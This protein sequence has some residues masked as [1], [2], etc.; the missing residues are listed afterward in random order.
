MESSIASGLKPMYRMPVSFGPCAGPRNVPADASY[1]AGALRTASISVSALSDAD[2]LTEL[3]PDGC[4]LDGEPVLTAMITRMYDIGWLAGRSY[5][6]LRVTLPVQFHHQGELLRGNFMPVLWESLADPIVT[7]RDELGHPKLWAEIPDP[8]MTTDGPTERRISGTASWLGFRFFELKATGLRDTPPPPRADGPGH[9]LTAKY[10]PRTGSWGEA[11]V[12]Y[13]TFG[14]VRPPEP[15]EHRRGE[16][17]F[18][19]RPARWE[20]MPTQYT[21]VSALAALPLHEFRSASYVETASVAGEPIG[22][23]YQIVS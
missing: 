1:E 8:V 7:G 22:L 17:H 16:G 21:V 2:V 20:D 23:N 6:I 4:E 18:A 15:S 12:N 14:R 19:F 11:D 9:V 3:L 5:N 13:L 10:V